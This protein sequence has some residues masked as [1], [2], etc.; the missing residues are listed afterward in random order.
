[1]IRFACS[2]CGHEL[3]APDE[4]AGAVGRCTKCHEHN[5]V[6]SPRVPVP[7]SAAG[8]DE[9]SASS[10]SPARSATAAEAGLARLLR[11]KPRRMVVLFGGGALVLAVGAVM[12]GA[13]RSKQEAKEAQWAASDAARQRFADLLSSSEAKQDRMDL[14]GAENDA[15]EAERVADEIGNALIRDLARKRLAEIRWRATIVQIVNSWLEDMK[16]GRPTTHYWDETAVALGDASTLFSVREWEVLDLDGTDGFRAE[17]R[18]RIDSS[19]K[20]GARIT[21]DW[22]VEL[23]YVEGE[24]GWLIRKMEAQ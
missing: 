10:S 18:V 20:G 1:M 8:R 14:A 4:K 19:N 13:I 21:K 22:T 11:G 16:R 9:G 3:T 5:R 2:K 15:A 7:S 24:S 12:A 17:V 6:P 23:G